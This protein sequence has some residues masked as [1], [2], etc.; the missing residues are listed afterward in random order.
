MSEQDAVTAAERAI[1]RLEEMSL[2]LRACAILDADGEQLAASSAADWSGCAS[3]LWSAATDASRPPPSQIHVATI[4]GEVFLVRL[5]GG[6][7]AIAVADRFALA[8]LMFCDLRAALRALD[9]PAAE[10][11]TAGGS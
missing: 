1:A 7:S 4:E 3:E 6:S 2:D 5:S 11:V 8:S 9:A 10:P